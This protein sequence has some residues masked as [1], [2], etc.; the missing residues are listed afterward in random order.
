MAQFDVYVNPSQSSRAFYPYLVDI[1]TPYIA[2]LATRIVIPLG[3]YSAF[4]GQAMKG[5]TPIITFEDE[6][7]LL[8]PTKRLHDPIG[9]LAHLRDR[10]IGA[11]D[12]ALTGF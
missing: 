2:E 7:L 1:Q 10:I 4:G 9:T 12:F 5:L 8:L 11:V 6:K 3:L